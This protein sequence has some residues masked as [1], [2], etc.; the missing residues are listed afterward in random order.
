MKKSILLV[1]MALLL[2]VGMYAQ[3]EISGY[4]DDNAT[5]GINAAAAVYSI[6]EAVAYCRDLV[7][8]GKNDWYL[9]SS[10]E[11]LLFIPDQDLCATSYP[12]CVSDAGECQFV[13]N[14]YHWTR[15]NTVG[16][17]WDCIYTFCNG[18][19]L[20][21]NRYSGAAQQYLRCVR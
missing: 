7:E 5:D 14:R 6:D 13:T 2:S 3:T 18:N 19:N 21:Y 9:P 12:G 17:G 4:A 11:L 8:D 20:T 10:A 15:S 1:T 16:N